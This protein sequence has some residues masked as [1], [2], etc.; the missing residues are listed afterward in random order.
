[1]WMRM[2]ELGARRLMLE[3]LVVAMVVSLGRVEEAYKGH[4]MLASPVLLLPEVVAV[5]VVV[6]A[7]AVGSAFVA[8]DIVAAA[9][10]DAAIFRVVA[11]TILP[12][13]PPLSN[14]RSC[15]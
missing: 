2:Y 1:M 10:D 9:V 6:G 3:W 14:Q 4:A 11:P 5:E 12:R 15:H 7:V 13:L 8:V